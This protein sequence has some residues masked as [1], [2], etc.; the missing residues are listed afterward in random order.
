MPKERCGKK[1][2]LMH[3]AAYYPE[4]WP[5][6]FIQ[7]DIQKM[8]AV[9]LNTMR[10]GEF[11][12]SRM[13]PKEG[14]FDFSWLIHV[15]DR[16]YAAGI[17]VVL[18]TPSA[19]PPQWLTN[20]YPEV[21]QMRANGTRMQHGAR[22]HTC[23]TSPV[24]REKC[25]IITEELCKATKGHPA[26]VGWQLD[27]E[28]YPYGNGCFCPLCTAKFRGHLERKFGTIDALNAAWDMTRWSLTYESFDTI[29]APGN[30]QWH[31]PSLQYEWI[32]FMSD[33]IV[34]ILRA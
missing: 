33:T 10:I 13:E 32:R 7:D 8:K 6:E 19:T 18:C 31:H 26:V 30:D 20:R 16:L 22:K 21:L 11:A 28:P 34:E 5:E 24:F 23:H 27:N 29:A 2:K 15:M 25:A 12:W 14:E 9:G 3:G 4:V 1:M 17:D